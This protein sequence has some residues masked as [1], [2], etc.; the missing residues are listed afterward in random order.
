MATVARPESFLLPWSVD[1]MLARYIDWREEAESSRDDYQ[2]WLIAPP[3]D[4]DQ[5]FAAY[6]APL[7]REECAAAQYAAAVSVVAQTLYES[8]HRPV[9]RVRPYDT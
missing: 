9:R 6:L 1:D 3:D 4:G 7:E 2:H 5:R 8:T